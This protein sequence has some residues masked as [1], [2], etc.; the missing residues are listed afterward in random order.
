MHRKKR[1]VLVARSGNSV[2]VKPVPPP[3]LW[4]K[5]ATVHAELNIVTERPPNSFTMSEYAAK[6]NMSWSCGARR[7]KELVG[8][9]RVRRVGKYYSIMEDNDG[10]SPK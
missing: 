6:F 7:L 4:D 9:G 8:A 2:L 1:A 10:S 3:N 5:L